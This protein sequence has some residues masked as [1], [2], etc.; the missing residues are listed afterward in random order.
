[1]TKTN[2][3]EA[4]ERGV[5]DGQNDSFS[6]G[7]VR[8]VGD[9]ISPVTLLNM[10]TKDDDIYDKGYDYGAKHRHDKYEKVSTKDISQKVIDEPSRDKVI[11]EPS[12]DDSS[13]EESEYCPS[14]GTELY[15]GGGCSCEDDDDENDEG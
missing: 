1:M 11:D 12:R 3:D 4:Y 9:L 7:I 2:N 10:R 15:G 6:D 8:A 14:C 5:H 13:S